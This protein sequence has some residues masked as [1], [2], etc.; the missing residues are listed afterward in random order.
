MQAKGKILYK[1][2]KERLFI[3]ITGELRH[4]MSGGFEALLKKY[5][6]EKSIIEDILVDM[7]DA[8]YLDSTNLGLLAQVAR[9]LVKRFNHKPTLL[10]SN[11]NILTLLETMGFDQ[12]FTIIKDKDSCQNGMTEVGDVTQDACAKARM[13]LEAHR[14]LVELNARNAQVFK[15]VV[16]LLEKELGSDITKE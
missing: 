10:C 2:D 12:I 6:N 14:A 8:V 15:N 11:K 4:T 16:E 1:E 13:M 3:R 5:L 7:N 9:Y